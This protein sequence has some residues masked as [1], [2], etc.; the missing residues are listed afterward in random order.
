RIE[1]LLGYTNNEFRILALGDYIDD[2][3]DDGMRNKLQTSTGGTTTFE[4]RFRR[5]DGTA[6]PV[7][8][9]GTQAEW[10][11]QPIWMLSCRDITERHNTQLHLRS[12]LDFSQKIVDVSP[13]GIL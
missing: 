10:E 12:L 13:A 4:T 2:L 11:N 3:D 7:E 1:Q 9:T 6:V 8:V 5:R